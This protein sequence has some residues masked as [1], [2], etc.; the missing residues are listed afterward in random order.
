MEIPD[1]ITNDIPKDP[2][3]NNYF[4]HANSSW[5]RLSMV[6][7]K[8]LE[9]IPDDFST[10]VNTLERYYKGF[11]K[12]MEL[13]TNYSLPRV[14]HHENDVEYFLKRDHY[15]KGLVKEIESNFINISP[16]Y[17]VEQRVEHDKFLVTL[18]WEYTNARY[19]TEPSF[20]DF[21]KVYQ[22]VSKQ[23]DALY[24]YIEDRLL[25]RAD[26]KTTEFDVNL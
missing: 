19:T 22:F 12:A 9:Y 14:K 17:T 25:Q 16:T 5:K 1:F 24:E 20:D 21:F 4:R 2:L 11:L 6:A 8:K 26:D 15:L 23:K 18:Q 3:E 7:E 10:L 13:H